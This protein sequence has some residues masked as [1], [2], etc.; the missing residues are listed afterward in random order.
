MY[1]TNFFEKKYKNSNRPFSA[2]RRSCE[3]MFGQVAG[4][5]LYF[6]FWGEK[7]FSPHGD[8]YF[9][10]GGTK[11]FQLAKITQNMGFSPEIYHF[12]V[13]ILP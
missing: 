3:L 7:Y 13:M 2:L 9:G 12:P 5:D 6:R 1:I 8:R 4:M 10:G 11:Y